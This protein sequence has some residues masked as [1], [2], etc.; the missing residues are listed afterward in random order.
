[1]HEMKKKRIEFQKG[2]P[3]HY[4]LQREI[5]TLVS[6]PNPPAQTKKVA[7]SLWFAHDEL[8]RIKQ[9][10]RFSTNKQ[11]ETWILAL[12]IIWLSCRLLVEEK[13]HST[14]SNV[15]MGTSVIRLVE[16]D[17]STNSWFCL[18]WAAEAK[19]MTPHQCRGLL[20]GC[21]PWVKIIWSF[22]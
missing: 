9:F 22:E 13:I 20:S 6:S 2:P 10:V 3:K 1:M 16:A 8:Q 11:Y 21:R 19:N 17:I 15:D 12:E 7:G 5:R 14:Q 18:S 4:F